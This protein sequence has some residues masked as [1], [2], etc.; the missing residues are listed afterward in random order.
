MDVTVRPPVLSSV[1][2]I[3]AALPLGGGIATGRDRHH[4]ASQPCRELLEVVTSTSSTPSAPRSAV[5]R[6]AGRRPPRRPRRARRAGRSPE[7][8][9][10]STRPRIDDVFFGD[11]NGAGE[12]NRDVARMAALLAGLPTSVPG[13]TVNRLVRLRARSR[14]PGRPC[15][16]PRRRAARRRRRR[17]VDEPRP[18]G[19]AQAG[20]RL[21]ARPRDAALDD[22]RLAHGQPADA[23]AR[24]RSR[25]ARA[26]RSSPTSYG[27]SREAQDA[28]AAR[29]ATGSA[30]A[31]LGGRPVSTRRSSPCPAPTRPRRVDPRR[32][33]PLE[34]LARLKPAFRR[35]RHGHGRQLLPAQR[36]RGRPADRRRAR[37]RA[38]TR[39]RAARPGRAPRGVRGVDPRRLRHRPGAGGPHARWR[40]PGIGWATS[41][42]VELNEAFAAQALACLAEWP[43][44]DP[45]IVNPQRRRDRH[46]PPARRLRRPH[47]SATLA[48][49]LARA[50]GGLGPRHPLHRRRPGA[51]PRPR[52]LS[53]IDDTRP[54]T[55]RGADG[56]PGWQPPLALHARLP[57][58]PR[59]ARHASRWSSCRRRLTETHRPG[60]RRAP[61]RRR[62]T[63]DLTRQHAR[64]AAR[65]SASSCTAGSSTATAGR[66]ADTLVEIWQANAAGRYRH[67]ARPA[68]GAARPELHRRRPLPHRRRGPLPVRHDQAGRLPVAQPPQR[69]APGAHPLL[70]VRHAR[71]P[72]GW[73]PRCTSRTT[74]CSPTTRSSTRS[75]DERPAS[76]LVS[77]L[78]P[79]RD[80]A[81]VGARLPVRHRAAR[82][83]RDAV[84]GRRG[85]ED[86]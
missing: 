34:A 39:P 4:L 79:G 24:G 66:S 7:R 50:G 16:R 42:T 29:A 71:S 75:R 48:H 70:A 8:S 59:C 10:R 65:A 32:T 60:A 61:A 49:Q 20:A 43:E 3:L 80:R 26:P 19:A 67:D 57:Q 31:R 74:R 46:R 22:A 14:H 28:F 44:L 56:R 83:R 86:D 37:R 73:S 36:R 51:R 77:A 62:S 52:G 30:A 25:S 78:R 1:S 45:A 69:L 2:P 68:P 18:L 35:G 84:R 13:V 54:T 33:P 23:G 15:R 40:G 6:R 12:D 82:P 63:H 53:M 64:R 41:R 11:A 58:H 81:G 5:R 55:V 47:R 85:R 21:P 17:R 27:I 72:S 9:P 38:A 76:A